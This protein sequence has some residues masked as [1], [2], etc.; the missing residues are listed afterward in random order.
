MKRLL[1]V[2]IGIA[3]LFAAGIVIV[4]YLTGDMV[5]TADAFFDAIRRQD[6]AAARSSLSEDFKASTDEAAL[7]DFLSR[8]ALLSFK[9]ASWSHRQVSGGRGELDGAVTTQAGGVVPLKLMF[10]KENGAWKIYAI[11]KP[12]AGLQGDQTSPAVPTPAAQVALVKASMHDF[13]VAVNKK[14]MNDFYASLSR[15]WQRQITVE[16]L[17]KAYA[18]ILSQ[19][20]DLTVLDR[21][22]PIVESGASINDSGFLVL[23][24]HFPSRPTQVAFEQKYTYE[25][26]AWKLTGFGIRATP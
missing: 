9:E 25:G 11:Q 22:D 5:R 2:L 18:S 26:T 12:T 8:G 23:K 20:V 10:V 16:G 1:Q 3:L 15:L 4:L 17:N 21:I 6:L 13:A 19:T 24:G 7:R 14:T